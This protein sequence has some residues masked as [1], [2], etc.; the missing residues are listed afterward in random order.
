MGIG[1]AVASLV[2]MTLVN[3]VTTLMMARVAIAERT[4]SFDLTVARVLGSRALH[5]FQAMMI[6][7]QL[8]TLLSYFILMGD[9]AVYVPSTPAAAH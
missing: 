3:Y 7:G 5:A 6:V 1:L 2:A 4:R 8:G 9:F